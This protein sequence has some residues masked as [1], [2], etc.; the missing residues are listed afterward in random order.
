MGLGFRIGFYKVLGSLQALGLRVSAYR[1][2]G[3][4]RVYLAEMDLC[5]C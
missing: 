5:A 2:E 3:S 1:V 4:I